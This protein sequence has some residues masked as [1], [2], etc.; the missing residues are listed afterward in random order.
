[1]TRVGPG[2]VG[3]ALVAAVGCAAVAARHASL[4]DVSPV[5]PSGSWREVWTWAVVGAL[6]LYAFGVVLVRVSGA[7]LAVVVVSAVAI[8]ALPLIA[9]LLLSKDVYAYWSQ[10][11]IVSPH[12]G[13]P[14]RDTPASFSSDPAFAY[15]SESWRRTTTEY[16]PLWELVSIAPATAAG[17]RAHRAQLAY[18]IVAVLG[19]LATVA[20]VLRRTRNAAAVAFVGWNPLVALHFAGGG[21][22]DAWLAVLLALGVFGAGSARAGAAWSAATFFKG[23]P[24]LFVPLELARVRLGPRDGFWIGLGLMTAALAAVSFG[25]F[26]SAWITTA[27]SGANTPTGL[28]GVHWLEQLGLRYRYAVATGALLF[29]CV[30]AGLLVHAWRRGRARFSLAAAAL[31]LTAAQ[32]RPWYALWPVVLAGAEEDA[33]A[34]VVAFALTAYLLLADAVSL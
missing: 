7:H 11:R 16:A 3:G 28:G 4:S 1:V 29:A 27:F 9:P 21:H 17:G 12:G 2:F 31:C 5:T 14:Y 8:Q 10:A 22:N 18:R 23:F 34:A 30:Y 25:V 32:L 6:V 13:N 15:V 26:G 33:L 19:V 20:L 24:G